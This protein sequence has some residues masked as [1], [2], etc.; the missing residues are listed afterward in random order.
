MSDSKKHLSESVSALVDGEVSELELHRIL[1]QLQLEESIDSAETNDQS[2]ANKW[3]R[4]NLISQALANTPMSG[5]D[6]SQSVSSAIAKEQTYNNHFLP[7][8]FQ[9][10]SMGRL[11]IAASV[12]FMAV[13]GVQQLNNVNPLQNEGLQAAATSNDSNQLQRPANQFPSGFQPM[14]EA[15]MVNAGGVVKTSQHPS[16][17]IKLYFPSDKSKVNKSDLTKKE[18]NDKNTDKGAL[19]VDFDTQSIAK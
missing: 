1:K 11:A 17:V 4:Y 16:K 13:M 6:I 7:G 14:I 3:S 9:A 5:K 10:T 12:A 15:R 2:I 8:I 19:P 18:L